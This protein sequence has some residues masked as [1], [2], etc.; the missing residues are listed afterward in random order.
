MSILV[1][2]FP[3][4]VTPI[5]IGHTHLNKTINAFLIGLNYTK[6]EGANE[7]WEAEAL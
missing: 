6:Q 3:E 1:K 2:E 4:V 7:T 5:H